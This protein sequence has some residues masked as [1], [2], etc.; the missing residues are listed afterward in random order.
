MSFFVS[1]SSH[2]SLYDFCTPQMQSIHH[3]GLS[4]VQI[5]SCTERKSA[6][7]TV[8]WSRT[9]LQCR[10]AEQEGK[11][12]GGGINWDAE[13]KKAKSRKSQTL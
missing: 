13:W 9:R 10:A 8:R 5:C 6:F 2:S 7:G 4:P 12:E 11:G 3:Q 1:T